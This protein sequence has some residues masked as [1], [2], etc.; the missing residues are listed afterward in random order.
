M[1]P[2]LNFYVLSLARAA[3]PLG[4]LGTAHE[5]VAQGTERWAFASCL[6]L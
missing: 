2:H 1:I 3:S 5:M 4:S 6:L